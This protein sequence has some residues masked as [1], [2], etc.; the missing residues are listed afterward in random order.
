MSEVRVIL[1]E[2]KAAVEAG[3]SMDSFA[4]RILPKEEKRVSR[5]WVFAVLSAFIAAFSIFAYFYFRSN[6][7]PP[8]SFENMTLRKLSQTNDVSFVQITPDGRSI[9]YHTLNEDSSRSLWIRQIQEKNSLQLISKELRQFWGG[10]GF[11]PDG[12]W[13]FYSLADENARQG[14]LYRISSLGGTPRK[15]VEK[16]NDVGSVSSEGK[17]ILFVR[18]NENEVLQIMTANTADGGDEQIIHT[19]KPNDNFRDPKFSADDKS[20][21]SVNAKLLMAKHFGHWLRF[22]RQAEQKGQFWL[23]VETELASWRF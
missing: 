22:R 7:S 11:S 16:A 1:E 23:R 14:T 20:V 13:I 4:K 6:S 15:L 17:R 8:I 3:V 9:V 18:R 19:G 21:F 10:I 12:S 2:V 5:I